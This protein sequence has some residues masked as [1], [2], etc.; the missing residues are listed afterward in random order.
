MH[1]PAQSFDCADA[2]F[3]NISMVKSHVVSLDGLKVAQLLKHLGVD[4]GLANKENHDPN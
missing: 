4:N 3:I 1:T 2:V